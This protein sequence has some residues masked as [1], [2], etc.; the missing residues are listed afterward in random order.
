MLC[1]TVRDL[2]S[3][4]VCARNSVT[5]NFLHANFLFKMGTDLTRVPKVK[6]R[7]TFGKEISQ[8]IQNVDALR[9]RI[10]EECE[11]LNQRVIDNAVKQWR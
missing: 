6:L 11:R 5:C 10:I 7:T 1:D 3:G 2:G 4:H 8:K 9:Q